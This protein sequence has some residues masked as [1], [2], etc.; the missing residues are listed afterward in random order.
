MLDF[1]IIGY[2][3]LG[4]LDFSPVTGYLRLKFGMV[5]F[6][7]PITGCVELGTLDFSD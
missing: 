1:S 5:D 2:L 3:E 7:S 6:S 4:T